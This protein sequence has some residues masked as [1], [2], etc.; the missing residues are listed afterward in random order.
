LS[1]TTLPA[2]RGR[3]CK[4]LSFW[5][6][7]FRAEVILTHIHSLTDEAQEN[8]ALGRDEAKQEAADL[9]AVTSRLAQMG[10]D[11]KK[12][13]R[14]G[15]VGDTL[16]NLCCEENIDLLLLGAY[17]FGRQ[18][19]SV[20][21]S[22]AEYLLRAVPCVAITYGPNAVA[23]FSCIDDGSPILV[24][25]FLPCHL[26]QLQPA[27]EIA[28]LFGKKLV[29]LHVGAERMPLAPLVDTHLKAAS[30]A[31]A[32]ECRA[33]NVEVQIEVVDGQPDKVI[34]EKSIQNHSPFVLMPLRWHRRLNSISSDN[35]AAGVI[36][37][38]KVPVMT[39]RID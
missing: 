27:A 3:R 36:R 12:I 16:F 32:A 30:E 35:V 2:R 14:A 25:I 11:G 39:F 19:R 6:D 7:D 13:V 29:L 34:C 18:D 9:D 5:Q 38:S 20:L 15:F 17:G 28:K 31:L 10:I 1:L 22:T 24:P 37:S 33:E 23:S 8:S 21:G 4:T 26:E